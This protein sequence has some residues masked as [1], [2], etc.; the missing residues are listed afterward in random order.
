MREIYLKGFEIAIKGS[1]PLA[2]M[3][4][5]NLVNGVH[6]ANSTD[7]LTSICRGEWG[8]EGLI[9]TDWGTTGGGDLMEAAGKKYG[10]SSPA[11]CIH[12]GNDLIMPGSQEDV[13]AI[14][15][16]AEHPETG[17]LA[18]EELRASAERIITTAMKTQE[19]E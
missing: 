4:S 12:A 18:I 7:L 6:T 13:D 8:Y 16:A 9:M 19:G 15:Y 3:T 1:S 11:G 10:C 5:Y 2:L 17:E 14:I